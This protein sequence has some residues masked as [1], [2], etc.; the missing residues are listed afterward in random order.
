MIDWGAGAYE[1]TAARLV[2]AAEATVGKLAPQPG[3]RVLDVGC[4]TGNAALAAARAGASVIGIDPAERLVGVARERAAAEGLE[5]TFE[6]AE[7]TAIPAADDSFD[8]AVSV[9]AVIFAEPAGAARELVRVVRPGGRIVLTTWTPE[10]PGAAMGSVIR[11]ALGAP[12][13]TPRWSDP[14][15]VRQLF[16]PREVTCVIEELPFYAASVEEYLE[17]GR[18]NPMW[19]AAEGALRG[20]GKFDAVWARLLEL[21]EEANEDP[22]A[23]RTTSRYHLMSVTV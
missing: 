8:A 14:D 11:E 19:L 3:E 9:F 4:G 12:A 10:G 5:A 6:V 23:F 1:L 22:S 2:P 7:A 15:F 20:A 21:F 16:A 18:Q 13:D 17:E